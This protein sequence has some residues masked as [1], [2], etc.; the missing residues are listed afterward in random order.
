[1]KKAAIISIGSEIMS[2]KIDDTN[3]TYISKWLT[4]IGIS[5]DYRLST[6]DVIEDI[7]HAIK[8]VN[9]CDLIILT[10]GLGP[11]SDDITREALTKYLNKKLVFQADEYQKIISFF[12]KLNRPSPES[13]KKQ[14]DLIE[15]AAF[16][17]N[18]NGTAPGMFYKD[19][20]KIFVLLP[21]PPQENQPMIQEQLSLRLKQYGFVGKDFNT[22]IYRLYNIGESAIADMFSSFRDDVSIGYYATAGGWLEIHINENITR[23]RQIEKILTDNKVFFTDDKDIS[24]LVLEKLKELG[25]TIS[26]AESITGGNISG[27][28]VK[29]SGASKVFAGSIVSYSN[30]IKKNVLG[31]SKSSLDSHG[32]VSE[33]VVKEMCYGLKKLMGTNIAIAVS[34]I[35]GPEGGSEQKPVGTV[36]SGFLFGNN[37]HFRKDLFPGIRTRI[38][39]RVTNMVFVEILKNL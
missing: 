11:T 34:G 7:V 21:G 23:K 14:A 35:A 4:G 17:Y 8:H 38:M 32:A 20:D 33:E 39:S 28:F 24:L 15:G 12:K 29:N 18:N 37:F 30:E 31:V 2:G 10:G 19:A 25:Q 13:N 26:F 36:Y 16:L 9:T 1:M 27:E 22:K 5:V 3:S 6:K